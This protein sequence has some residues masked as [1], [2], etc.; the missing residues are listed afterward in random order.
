MEKDRHRNLEQN[1]PGY[2]IEIVMKI[3]LIDRKDR[4]PSLAP[5]KGWLYQP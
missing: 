5:L 2:N 1:L 3:D 4:A